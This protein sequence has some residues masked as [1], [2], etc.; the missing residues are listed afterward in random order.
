[1]KR[2]YATSDHSRKG[3]EMKKGSR[4]IF[5]LLLS[6]AVIAVPSLQAYW[7]GEGVP[8]CTAADNQSSQYVYPDAAGGAYVAWQDRRTGTSLRRA[9]KHAAGIH[10]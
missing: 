5:L 6:L 2:L 1:M 4:M 3:A 10:R 9:E 8:V 7:V